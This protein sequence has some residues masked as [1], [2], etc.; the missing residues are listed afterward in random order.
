M[1][2]SLHI[3]ALILSFVLLLAL[4][5]ISQSLPGDSGALVAKKYNSW[6]GVLR[7]WVCSRWSCDGS[8]ISWLN[9]C[10]SE[11]EKSHPGVYIEFTAVTEQ[12]LNEAADS[13]LRPPELLFF[14]PGALEN[15]AILESIPNGPRAAIS[16]DNALPV[17]MGAYA[18]V[19]NTVLCDTIPNTPIHLPDETGRSFSKAAAGLAGA[20]Q[21]IKLADPGID[22]GLAVSAAVPPSLDAFINGDIPAIII[23]QRE[24]SKLLRLRDAGKGPDWRCVPS[25]TSMYADQLLLGGVT[26]QHDEAASLRTPLALSFLD[27]LL[28]DECQQ[29]LNSIG[30]FPATGRTIYPAASAYSTMEGMLHSLPLAAP[31]LFWQTCELSP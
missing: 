20:A 21:E 14:S 3:I 18:W 8:F 30:A 17:C 28:R 2:R 6:S 7:A 9:R 23:S 15:P 22:L 19:I 31:E 5:Q 29:Q 12:A 1:K 25:G 24:L 4:F 16:Y 26:V 13:S 27:F 10:A 11:F